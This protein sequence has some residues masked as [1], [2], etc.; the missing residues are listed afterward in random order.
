MIAVRRREGRWRSR[1]QTWGVR[2]RVTIAASTMLAVIL[3]LGS[4]ALLGLVNQALLANLDSAAATRASDIASLIGTGPLPSSLPAQG[5]ENSLIQVIDFTN[6]VVSASANISGEPSILAN[7]PAVRGDTTLDIA[8]LPVGSS[9]F[10]FRVT[11]HPVMLASGPGWIYVAT[12]L[13]QVEAATTSLTWMLAAALP[14]LIALVGVTVFLSAG[15]SLK[16]IE[17]IR[18]QAESI[19][20]DVSKRVPVPPS[21]DE[22]SRLAVTM[23]QML[24]QLQASAQK[25]K[26][27]V[28]DA[29]HELR[30][31]LATLRAQ[32]EISLVEA[33]KVNAMETL[34]RVQLQALRM[35]DLIEDLLFLARADESGHHPVREQ[36]DL[37]EVVLSEVRRLEA[38]GGVAV[39]LE[40][41]DGVRMLGSARDLARMLRNIGDNA[42]RHTR[43]SVLVTLESDADR[44]VISIA[45]D[46]PPIPDADQQR[47]FDRF[48]RLDDA[49]S[50][51]PGDG[52][53]GLGLAIAQEI[54]TFHGGSITVTSAA[55]P[56][57]RTEFIISLPLGPRA[58]SEVPA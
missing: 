54:A 4:L 41:L 14:T 38:A 53:S 5:D 8:S 26:R 18:R 45:N 9:S 10:P 7:P 52:G 58:V 50:R 11:A 33:D 40:R 47:I 12:S 6:M 35:S 51:Q 44:A 42:L 24:D 43:T 13:S 19:G 36:V 21:H 34:A 55:A 1:I 30:S 48:T 16:P 28:G 31:P 25:Q 20:S 17:D 49:R 37:D 2:A 46:G 57:P 29:S 56:R 27:F 15:R 22:V 23:N 32:V 3:A 39:H